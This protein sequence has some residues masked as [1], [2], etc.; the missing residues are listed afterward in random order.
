MGIAL[1]DSSSALVYYTPLFNDMVYVE[2]RVTLTA[3]VGHTKV[4]TT[5]T[6][7]CV[8]LLSFQSYLAFKLYDPGEEG[9]V[10]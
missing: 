8:D 2:A 7:S 10:I 1:F 9:G 3:S 6:S 5:G 4:K